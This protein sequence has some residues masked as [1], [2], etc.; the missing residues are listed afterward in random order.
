M[1][2]LHPVALSVFLRMRTLN[3]VPEKLRVEM[4]DYK[5]VY[6]NYRG[7]AELIRFILAHAGVAY[8]DSR[9]DTDSWLK[10]RPGILCVTIATFCIICV[11]Y[12]V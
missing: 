10:Q 4:A 2:K 12:Y 3:I 9:I 8:E 11:F 5:L 7:R 6:L 1:T